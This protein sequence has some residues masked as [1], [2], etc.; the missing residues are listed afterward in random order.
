MNEKL[1]V[2]RNLLTLM[3]MFLKTSIEKTKALNFIVRKKECASFS[4]KVNIAE[5]FTV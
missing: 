1:E 3:K 2:T 4:N 5:K